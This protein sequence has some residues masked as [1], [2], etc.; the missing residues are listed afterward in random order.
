MRL[1]K[2]FLGPVEV[3]CMVTGRLQHVQASEPTEP[4]LCRVL[5]FALLLIGWLTWNQLPNP[6]ESQFAVLFQ[7]EA[8][9]L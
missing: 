6:S 4:L 3:S 9:F 1:V 2:L 8:Q 7:R 5:L